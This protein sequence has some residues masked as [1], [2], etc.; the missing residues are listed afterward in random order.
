MKN[1]RLMGKRILL[2]VLTVSLIT[3]IFINSSLDAEMST[4]HSTGVREF[5]NC[6]LSA[7]NI[8]IVLSENFVRK[9]AH[10]VEYFVL[11]TLLYYTVKSF[12]LKP[13]KRIMTA[14]CVGLVVAVIDEC[15]QLF[16]V[17]RS[18]Q[19]TDV[20]LDFSAVV[21]ATIIWISVSLFI[22]KLK[23]RKK[24]NE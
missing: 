5:I 7:L 14:P 16:S 2:C 24:E 10:F 17:G 18:A 13:D 4:V 15:I 21:F 3:F 11:G 9:C 8:G 19:A 6:V 22:K 23:V 1:H 20:L 12:I